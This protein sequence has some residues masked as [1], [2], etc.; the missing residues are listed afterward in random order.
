MHFSISE[1]SS[2]ISGSLMASFFL[3]RNSGTFIKS[4]GVLSSNANRHA[5]S[6]IYDLSIFA[7]QEVLPFPV[8]LEVISRF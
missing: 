6:F 5:Q 4:A 8:S 3:A 2:A 1:I 7:A